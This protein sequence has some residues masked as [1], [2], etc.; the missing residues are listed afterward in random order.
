MTLGKNRGHAN[1]K[2]KLVEDDVLA[3]YAD[4]STTQ[5]KLA[6]KYGVKQSTINH[7]KQKRTWKWLTDRVDAK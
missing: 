6:E 2:S 5:T 4:T 7:I 3:I 1:F